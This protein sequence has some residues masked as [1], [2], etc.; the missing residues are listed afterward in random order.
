MCGFWYVSCVGCQYLFYSCVGVSIFILHTVYCVFC[1]TG[2][3]GT[4]Q[5]HFCR[6]GMYLKLLVSQ[7]IFYLYRKN[8]QP[9]ILA[10]PPTVWCES[11]GRGRQEKE[12][13]PPTRRTT[14]NQQPTTQTTHRRST[15]NIYTIYIYIYNIY[16]YI[17]TIYIYI[18]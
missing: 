2:S 7:F 5:Y 1:T 6:K 16:I 10:C 17:Y 15:I 8:N 12:G 4:G 14:N 9:I 3:T 13:K 11:S 18:Q